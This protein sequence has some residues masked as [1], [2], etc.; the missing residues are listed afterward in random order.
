MKCDEFMQVLKISKESE[1]MRLKRAYGQI[2]LEDYEL[3]EQ[4]TLHVQNGTYS[5]A[6][7]FRNQ[8][9]L[10]V[11]TRAENSFSARI[12][13]IENPVYFHKHRFI[14]MLYV[15]EGVCKHYIDT[16]DNEMVL[17]KGD[18]FLLSQNVIHAICQEDENAILIKIIVPIDFISHS[19]MAILK[20][21][22]KLYDFFV[23]AK[24][25]NNEYYNYLLFHECSKDV[26]FYIE[27]MM[28][29]YYKKQKNAIEAIQSYFQLMMIQLEREQPLCEETRYKLSRSTLDMGKVVQFIYEHSEDVT[30]EKLA[31]HFSFHQTYLSKII[32]ENYQMNF[33]DLLRECRLEKAIIM[34]ED[35]KYS[36][37]KIAELVGYKNAIPIYKGIK[38][39]YGISPTEFRYRTQQHAMN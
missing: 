30:L 19:L 22:D 29:E 5:V 15:Y 17:K 31:N 16:L 26:R 10:E 32:K 39:K 18:L 4:S 6:K 34:L 1:R 35:S 7:G 2:M 33:R 20:G 28:S 8:L 13:L 12:H 23:D 3:D 14:E 24:S 21:N 37:E 9:D 11:L 38:E 25:K 27:Q 36:V